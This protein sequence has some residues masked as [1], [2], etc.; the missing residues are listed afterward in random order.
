MIT[1]FTT[2]VHVIEVLVILSLWMAIGV[3][4]KG[5]KNNQE[6]IKRIERKK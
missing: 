1:I 4:A 3:V 5:V 6:R 2:L